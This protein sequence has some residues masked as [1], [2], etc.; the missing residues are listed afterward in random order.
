L[1]PDDISAQVTI[2]IIDRFG[3]KKFDVEDIIRGLEEQGPYQNVFLLE[4]DV[5]NILLVEI[6]RSLKELQL[7]F[8]GELTM[9]DAMDTLKSSL[10]LD[11]VP[12]TWAKR[13][14]NSRA[15]RAHSPRSKSHAKW[16]GSNL[17]RLFFSATLP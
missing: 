8:A 6:M 10:Y 3:E 5:M 12:A 16:I 1:S 15:H 4:M 2:D 17:P 13:A 7:G 9:S 14:F 11:R